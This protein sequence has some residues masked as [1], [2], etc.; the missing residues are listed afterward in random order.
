[1]GPRPLFKYRGGGRVALRL[2]S[3]AVYAIIKAAGVLF[4]TCL[5]PDLGAGEACPHTEIYIL[6]C[7]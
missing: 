3:I 6:V 5:A 1:M 7:G 4:F 2:T